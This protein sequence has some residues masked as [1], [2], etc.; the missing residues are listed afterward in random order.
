MSFDPKF[1]ELVSTMADIWLSMSNRLA[2][3]GLST[4]LYLYYLPGSETEAGALYWAT[5]DDDTRGLTLGDPEAY[6][7]HLTR[8]QVR[9]RVWQVA[10]R[11]PILKTGREE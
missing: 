11:L 2:I 5:E 7:S 4:A 8:D 3:S 6:R 10:M 9:A 1:E